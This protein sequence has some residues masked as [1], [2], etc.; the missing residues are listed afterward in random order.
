MV[1]VWAIVQ[2]AKSQLFPIVKVPRKFVTFH[3][4]VVFCFIATVGLH[5]PSFLMPINVLRRTTV[6]T[7]KF[8]EGRLFCNSFAR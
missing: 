8:C 5:L 3:F 1:L 2:V 6:E 4:L 7:V